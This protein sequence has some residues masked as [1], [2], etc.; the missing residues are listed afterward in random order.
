MTGDR[1]ELTVPARGEYAKA[2]RMTA[3]ALASRMGMSF[4]DVEDVRMAVD[5]A[6][7]HAVDGI[8]E[9]GD[10]T[11]TFALSDDTLGIAVCVGTGERELDPDA[12]SRA[13]LAGFILDSVCDHHEFV[14]EESGARW[15]R[16]TKQAKA[17][18]AD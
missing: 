4:D 7:V 11:F 15:L 3:S 16:I 5:E 17:V 18:H 1:V 10:V 13:S 9:S 12:E 8:G 2:V 14:S 6:F